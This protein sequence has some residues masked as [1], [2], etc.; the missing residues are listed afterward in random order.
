MRI[1]TRICTSTYD[2]KGLAVEMSSTRWQIDGRPACPAKLAMGTKLG[3]LGVDLSLALSRAE[4]QAQATEYEYIGSAYWNEQKATGI[5]IVEEL[6]TKVKTKGNGATLGQ[7]RAQKT[8]TE[9]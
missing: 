8:N 5:R 9:A 4:Q 2:K 3:S 1:C 7:V 6:K